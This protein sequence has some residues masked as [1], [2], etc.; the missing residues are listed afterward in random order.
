MQLERSMS[1]AGH[2]YGKFG[3]GSA[4]TL[5]VIP[6]SKGVDVRSELLAFHSKW[7]SS[8]IMALTVLGKDDL[9]QL[10][11]MVVEK[12]SQVVNKDVEIPSWLDHPYD[13]GGV[14]LKVVPIKD[15]RHLNIT[16][17][18]KDYSHEYQTKPVSYL[19]HLVGHEA[20]GSLLSELKS[21]G[22]VNNLV[23]GLKSGSNGFDFFIV[24][25]DLTEV[26]IEH[27]DEII[28]LTF[29]YFEM[30]RQNG[31][32]KWIFDEIQ[33]VNAMLFRFKDKE[34][35]MGYARSLANAIHKYP[36]SEVLSGPWLA[37]QWKPELIQE[38]LD[39]L[40]PKKVQVMIVSQKFAQDADQS[41][42]WYGTSYTM[43]DIPE[44]KLKAW[45]EIELHERLH[46]PTPNVFIPTDFELVA[47]EEEK[48]VKVPCILH[49]NAKSR[50]WYLQDNEFMKPKACLSIEFISP[51][52]Y[53][54]PHHSNL[55]SMF[56]RLFDDALT[57]YAY[58][59]EI[60]GLWY[61]LQPTKYG[62]LLQTRGYH[63]KQDVFL[64]KI[65]SSMKNFVVD[66]KRFEVLK[67]PYIR[68]L[69]NFDMEQPHSHASYR[70]QNL[71]SEKVWTKEEH[72]AA[73]LDDNLSPEALRTF[74]P[75]LLG[76]MHIE[77]FAHGNLTPE[78]AKNL[79]QVVEQGL[80]KVLPIPSNFLQRYR[81]AA[82]P[83]QFA[84]YLSSIFGNLHEKYL[85]NLFFVGFMKFLMRCIK[86]HVSC[87]CTKW[88][89]TPPD[90]TW[91]WNCFRKS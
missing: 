88:A 75:D 59:A 76:R 3:T 70:L 25:V 45:S 40:V 64:E 31:I 83:K 14:Q 87:H 79:L 61:S 52:A 84:G 41:E 77:M 44:T 80:G 29:Q 16:F 42:K 5:D 7:Y 37:S 73:A 34:R 90:P 28:Q 38:V 9:D 12:F 74:L 35:P 86:V 91:S 15:L 36:L 71:I 2:D 39:C 11:A 66:E 65:I 1:K 69:R 55:V 32:Q 85:Y 22:Y 26:G 47:R 56:V 19:S 43:E 13:Q 62:L 20:K 18:I 4:E 60:A 81:Q 72:L 49:D 68:G 63:Q 8:N 17:P 24:N 78:Q 50:L 33:N 58:N 57:E 10:E 46:L 54:D 23:A 48:A 53:V 21:L 67:E 82:L 30:I 51:L 6:K 27:T 89:K